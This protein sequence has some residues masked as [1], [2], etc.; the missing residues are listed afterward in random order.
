LLVDVWMNLDAI[1]VAE[2]SS[3]PDGGRS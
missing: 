3:Y 1:D 2:L